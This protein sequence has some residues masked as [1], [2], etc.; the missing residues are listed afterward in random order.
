MKHILMMI[1][2]CMLLCSLSAAALAEPLSLDGTVT[3]AYTSEVYASSTA[4][5][6]TLHVA[7]GQK[8]SAGD[9]MVTLRTTGVFA[10]ED[11]V[12]T[13]VFAEPGDLAETLTA[14]YGAAV[15]METQVLYTV[16]ATTERAYD[17]VA[18]KIVRI[19]ESVV[20]RSRTNESRKG[21]ASVTAVD[22]IN[23]TL[24][25]TEGSF[26]A[27]E[28]VEIFRGDEFAESTCVGRGDV[29]RNAPMLV[30]AEGRIVK[31]HVQPGEAVK[32][33][34]L[35]LETLTGSGSS[36]V[37]TAKCSG[38]VA[39]INAVQ[40]AVLTENDVAAVIW[41]QDAM[42][43]EASIH[44]L[45]LK[46]IAVGQQ[47]QLIFD[48]NEDSGKTMTGIVQRISSVSDAE[49]TSTAFKVIIAF[50]P[51]DSIRYGMNVTITTIE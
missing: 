51:D 36:A 42:Q 35:L 22:G 23:F 3:A 37:L 24:H 29:A 27:G 6:E 17:S 12:V 16:S 49:S 41:P 25:V 38:V 44:E 46:D 8:V 13:A 14:R 40:G 26:I 48:W 50:T 30:N 15:C 20:L 19:G 9:A 11:G 31:V 1:M 21:K 2:V 33:G 5:A 45:D 7:L 34:D 18:T 32:K 43:I 10:E 39:Q 28:T 47:V 4:I